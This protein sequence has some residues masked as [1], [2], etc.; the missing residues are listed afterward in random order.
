MFLAGCESSAGRI[1]NRAISEFEVGHLDQASQLLLQIYQ[2]HPKDAQTLYYL[3]RTSQAQG[4]YE[5][6]IYYYQ[7]SLDSDPSL[8]DARSR[9]GEVQKAAGLAGENLIFIP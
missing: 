4:A 7:A 6:A 2:K 9:L 1:R 5:K 8:A 3:G